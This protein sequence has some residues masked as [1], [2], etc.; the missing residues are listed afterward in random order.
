MISVILINTIQ[1]RGR[2]TEVVQSQAKPKKKERNDWEN[3]ALSEGHC[4]SSQSG[5]R[6]SPKNERFK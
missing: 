6:L 4:L 5:E 1:K 3:M 2:K